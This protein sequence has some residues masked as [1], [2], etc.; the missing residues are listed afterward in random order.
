MHIRY[1]RI[2]VS[3]VRMWSQRSLRCTPNTC[4]YCHD[5]RRDLLGNRRP[6]WCHI[7]KMALDIGKCRSHMLPPQKPDHPSTQRFHRTRVRHFG[8]I[9]C[10]WMKR[11]I[12]LF[13]YKS[14]L[15]NREIREKSDSYRFFLCPCPAKITTGQAAQTE[16]KAKQS[17]VMI[18]KND[19]I[20]FWNGAVLICT[21][22]LM[23]G[24]HPAVLYII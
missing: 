7:L 3:P 13:I 23:I 15:G 11:S 17:N 2:Y 21:S 10:E 22:K 12:K 5:M 18:L 16:T 9:K 6:N 8:P 20:F 19:F 24:V 4:K 1:P 14:R